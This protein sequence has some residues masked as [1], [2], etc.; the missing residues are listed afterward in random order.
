MVVK[1]E[2]DCI[3]PEGQKEGE[4]KPD[5]EYPERYD[6]LQ[7]GYR[8]SE[9]ITKSSLGREDGSTCLWRGL[10]FEKEY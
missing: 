9:L 6:T 2:G 10:I 3:S 7:Q 8:R 4:L 1:D 5:N